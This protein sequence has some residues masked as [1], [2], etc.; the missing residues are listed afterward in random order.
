MITTRVSPAEDD[1]IQARAA[2]AG[3]AKATYVREVAKHGPRTEPLPSPATDLHQTLTEVVDVLVRTSAALSS[4]ETSAG[5]SSQVGDHLASELE[6]T[7]L[8]IQRALS[9]L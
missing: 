9:T 1:L 5:T 6:N 4:G 3:L 7:A 8:R 2:L